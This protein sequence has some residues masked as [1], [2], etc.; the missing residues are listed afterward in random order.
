MAAYIAMVVGVCLMLWAL[1][2]WPRRARYSAWRVITGM[3]G[4]SVLLAGGSL[5]WPEWATGLVLCLALAVLIGLWVVLELKSLNAGR[6]CANLSREAFDRTI[7]ELETYANR[8][9]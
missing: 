4:V 2:G 7:Q 6:E 8:F 9:R 5:V 3:G 1:A